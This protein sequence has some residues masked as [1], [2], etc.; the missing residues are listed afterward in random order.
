MFAHRVDAN[1]GGED[2]NHV[3]AAEVRVSAKKLLC[4]LDHVTVPHSD[5]A[6]F[7]SP[8]EALVMYLQLQPAT[9]GALTFYLPVLVPSE[10]EMGFV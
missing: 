7:F 4:V 3:I 10:V 8:G 2:A 6:M 5:I 9:M 1:A